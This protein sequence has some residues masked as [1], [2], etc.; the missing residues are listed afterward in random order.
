[1]KVLKYQMP[2]VVWAVIVYFVSVDPDLRRMFNAFAGWDKIIHALLYFVLCWLAW[3]AFTKQDFSS[4]VR[5]SASLGA[6]I[7][8]IVTSVMDEYNQS[9]FPGRTPEF[10]NVVAD[11]GGA[12][13]FV[14]MAWLRHRPDSEI[15]DNPKG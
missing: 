8:C 10:F 3:R 9:F 14:A 4:T 1:M 2:L 5:R 15:M 12:L 7:F 13:L 11:I 6:F